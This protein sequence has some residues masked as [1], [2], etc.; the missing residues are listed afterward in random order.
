[1]NKEK[2]GEIVYEAPP[3]EPLDDLMAALIADLNAPSDIPPEATLGAGVF[4]TAKVSPKGDITWERTD[5]C[6]AT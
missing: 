6:H 3:F 4:V 5:I 1:M 2:T